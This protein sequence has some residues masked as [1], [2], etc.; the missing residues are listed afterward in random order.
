LTVAF[1]R[2]VRG[3]ALFFDQIAD[4]VVV[5][6]AVGVDDAAPGQSV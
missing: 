1:G 3:R 6:G 2:D 4:A 5:M